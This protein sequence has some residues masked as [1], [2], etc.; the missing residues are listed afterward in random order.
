MDEQRAQVTI[1]AFADAK[2]ALSAAARSLPGHK[3][4]PRGKLAAILEALSITDRS[5]QRCRAQRPD[6]FD[7]TETLARLA[8][9]VQFAKPPIIGRDP[10]I[11][12][13]QL[14]CG[15]RFIH[16]DRDSR[17]SAHYA[18]P[19]AL[20]RVARCR[21]SLADSLHRQRNRT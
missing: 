4:K 12:F 8:A 2:R 14:P 11:E 10:P 17:R 19:P 1:A 7:L 21:S 3:P 5:H 6:A 16:P 20:G 15:H 18:R 13:A 9:P